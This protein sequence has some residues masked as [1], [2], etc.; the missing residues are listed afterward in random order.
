MPIEEYLQPEP[1]EDQHEQTHRYGVE[2]EVA[3][4]DLEFE[5]LAA[6]VHSREG[7]QS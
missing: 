4:G 7:R 2:K 1:T 3:E 5:L 6:A